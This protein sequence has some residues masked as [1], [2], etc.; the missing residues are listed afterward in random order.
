MLSTTPRHRGA[1]QMTMLTD[2]LMT[3]LMVQLM[4]VVMMMKMTMMTQLRCRL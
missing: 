2:L 3:L 4:M 1:E